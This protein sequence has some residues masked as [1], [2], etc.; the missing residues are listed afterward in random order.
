MGLK[1]TT[2]PEPM[3]PRR[4]SKIVEDIVI[5]KQVNYMD[6]ILI[7][8]ENHELEPEDIRKFVSKTLKEKVAINAQE[9]HYIPK[10]TAELPV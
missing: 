3:T 9:L 7:Y 6:A 1:M 10:T 2:N 5:D 8:C 4:F